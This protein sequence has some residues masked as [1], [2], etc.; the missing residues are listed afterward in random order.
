MTNTVFVT[1]TDRGYF[2]RALR[3]IEDLRTNGQWIGDIVLVAVDFEPPPDALTAFRV[4]VHR[5]E[6][7]KT[8]GLVRVLKEKPFV[9]PP[10]DNR[11]F[12]KLTQWDKLQ[13]FSDFFTKWHR[14][15]F[16]DAGLRVFNSVAPLLA[17]P[18]EGA[19]LA[20]D[21][22][23][24]Y[25]NGNRLGCQLDLQANPEATLRV[26]EAFGND[27][28]SY[29]YF[30]NCIFVFDTALIGRCN[31]AELEQAMNAYPVCRTNEMALMNLMFTVKHKVWRAFPQKTNEGKYLFGWCELNYRER[32][33]AS[34]FHFVKYP[35]IR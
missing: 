35:M 3:T 16:L 28:A 2:P 17:L 6:H 11:Q 9:N 13:V 20:P 25:D 21:D 33:A 7:L 15:C 22:S 8:D 23:D 31:L 1:L 34:E 24:P 10:S 19:L 12:D 32:P 27:V 14:V 5:V 26:L 4:L 30:L 29:R 18:Y